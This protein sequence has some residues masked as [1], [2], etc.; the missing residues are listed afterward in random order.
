L[1]SRLRKVVIDLTGQAVPD[2]DVPGCYRRLTIEDFVPDL[3]VTSRCDG[4]V[5]YERPEEWRAARAANQR[6]DRYARKPPG[7]R[8]RGQR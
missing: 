5:V 2:G 8:N 6:A 3:G 7:E 4:V 1:F